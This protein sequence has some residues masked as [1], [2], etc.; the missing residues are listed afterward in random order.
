[1]VPLGHAPFCPCEQY[2][3]PPEDWQL[4]GGGG[5]LFGCIGFGTQ[6]G[7]VVLKFAVALLGQHRP[8]AL[9]QDGPV[10]MQL[11]SE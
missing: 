5:G 2:S 4:L 6:L 7:G 8:C 9:P 10:A 1:M 11:L 3:E